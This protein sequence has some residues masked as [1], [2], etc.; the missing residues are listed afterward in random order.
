ML[1]ELSRPD[2]QTDSLS[3]WHLLC[4]VASDLKSSF[5][6][7]DAA[8]RSGDHSLADKCVS[9]VHSTAA[10]IWC[11]AAEAPETAVDHIIICKNIAGLHLPCIDACVP[12]TQSKAQQTDVYVVWSREFAANVGIEF[13]LPED[14]FG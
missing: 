6:I 8:G 3:E 14:T 1:H 13:K 11:C 4:H 10:C 12:S 5:Y 2:V 9:S 7:G